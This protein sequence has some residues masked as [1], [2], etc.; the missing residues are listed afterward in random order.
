MLAG[1]D[2]P[3]CSECGHCMRHMKLNPYFDSDIELFIARKYY[4]QG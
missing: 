1:K 3:I 2:N 4:V